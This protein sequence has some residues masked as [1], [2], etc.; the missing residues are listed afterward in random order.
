M[1][2]SKKYNISHRDMRRLMESI[3][4]LTIALNSVNIEAKRIHDEIEKIIETEE[5]IEWFR[6]A[7]EPQAPG[8]E[9]QGK[10]RQRLEIV[11]MT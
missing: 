9:K 1:K 3:S 2:K 7:L 6:C 8:L 4:S 10:A 11:K 5:T